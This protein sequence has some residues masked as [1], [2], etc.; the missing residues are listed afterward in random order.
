MA[1]ISLT[2]SVASAS[3]VYQNNATYSPN[4]AIDGNS[5]TYYNSNAATTSEHWTLDLNGIATINFISI[6]GLANFGNRLNNIQVIASAN[7]DFSSSV[8]VGT[9]PSTVST[10]SVVITPPNPISNIR[11]IRLQ[12][13][14]IQNAIN[15]LLTIAEV[16]IDGVFSDATTYT[17]TAPAISV[18]SV[19]V[20]SGNFTVALPTNTTLPTPVTITPSDNGAGG[21]FSPTTVQLSKSILSATF[22]YTPTTPGAKLI[23]TVN[24]GN[25]INPSTVRYTAMVLIP[26]VSAIASASSVYQNNATYSPNKA[27]DGNS[28]TYY[29]SNAATTSEHWTLDLDR[30]ATINCI[31]IIGLANFGNRLNNIQVIASAN[32]DFSSSVVVGTTPSTVSTQSVVITPPN[33]IS[34]IRYIRLQKTVIQNAINDLLTIAEVRIDGVF[35]DATTYTLTAPAISVGSVGVVS[36]NFTVALPTNTTLPTPVTITPSDNGAGGTF[37]PTTVQLSKSILSATFTYTPTTSGAKLISTVNNGNLINPSTVNYIAI[38]QKYGFIDNN[39]KQLN[40]QR[41]TSNRLTGIT[42]A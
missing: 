16:R 2:S 40:R 6:I 1:L 30:I 24:N 19:G 29:N 18:G 36:G 13:T 3:S 34:N 14:V 33:P 4:K 39:R 41:L 12:K 25:L 37:S 26:L 31:G 5:S 28:S 35:S 8:V 20:V 15:D 17:L 10:Q 9:T 11:Y 38:A 23:S 21:T 7:A 22:T 32:A 42:R 27:I